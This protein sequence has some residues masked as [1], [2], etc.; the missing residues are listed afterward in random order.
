MVSETGAFAYPVGSIFLSA[1]TTNPSTLLGYGTWSQVAQ[2]QFLVGYKSGDPNFG[3]LGATGGTIS[4]TPAGS[5]AAPTFTGASDTTSSVSAGTPAGTI[6]AHTTALESLTVG[7]TQILTAPTTHT[8][9]GSAL[10]GHTH[11]VTPTGTNSAPAL[12]GTPASIIPP[13]LVIYCWQRTA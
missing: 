13:F 2:G 9:T 3:T 4:Y 6:D 11:T 5:V 12:T 1:V 8:F 10:A 7:L